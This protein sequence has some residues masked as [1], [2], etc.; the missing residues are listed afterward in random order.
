MQGQSKSTLRKV[1][2]FQGWLEINMR[3]VSALF[4]GWERPLE[5]THFDLNAG[6]GYNHEA[7][8]IGSPLAF[9]EAA[10]K[11]PEMKF[12]A[13]FVELDQQAASELR[14]ALH[15]H[16]SESMN[17]QC[18]N[19]CNSGFL[20][21]KFPALVSGPEYGSVIL[22]PNNFTLPVVE[23]ADALRHC[24]RL[25]VFVNLPFTGGKRLRT[26]GKPMP[27][28]AQEVADLLQLKQD[29]LIRTPES[30]WQWSVLIGR[31]TPNIDRWKARGFYKLKDPTGYDILE[32]TCLTQTEREDPSGVFLQDL[33]RIFANA[34]I[35]KPAS[36][37]AGLAQQLLLSVW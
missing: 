27:V 14:T 2:D 32:N 3:I 24:Q 30:R 23:L 20:H 21:Y 5:Y 34:G 6:C 31:N 22:D 17:L 28:M 36:R 35:Q 25:D 18:Y 13:H 4:K 8:C 7:G 11:F 9:V 15:P 19:E 29:W 12:N 10:K 16:V 1:T 37:G 26:Y 33:R